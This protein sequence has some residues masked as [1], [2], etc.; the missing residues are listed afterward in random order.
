MLHVLGDSF[1]YL[2][3]GGGSLRFKSSNSHIFI[4]APTQNHGAA[5]RIGLA[6][7]N[8]SPTDFHTRKSGDYLTSTSAMFGTVSRSVSSSL[9]HESHS[10][11]NLSI[12]INL[13]R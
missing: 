4:S 1:L 11:A 2:Q 8:T 13:H 7:L 6:N 10:S 5:Q 9:L 3:G 12:K